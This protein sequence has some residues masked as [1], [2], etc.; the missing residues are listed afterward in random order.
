MTLPQ[1]DKFPIF[2]ILS[3][4]GREQ[5]L[6]YPL[7]VYSDKAL[8]DAVAHSNGDFVVEVQFKHDP[9]KP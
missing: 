8:A 6:G 1:H 4:G 7:Q 2:V 3:A 9:Y 5:S